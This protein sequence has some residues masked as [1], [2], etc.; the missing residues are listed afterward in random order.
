MKK[1]YNNKKSNLKENKNKNK[2][3][4]H[5]KIRERRGQT[6]PF[7]VGWAILQLQGNCGEEHTWLLSGNYESGV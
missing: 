3:I 5:Q 7:I 1:I 4:H 2:C 6:A